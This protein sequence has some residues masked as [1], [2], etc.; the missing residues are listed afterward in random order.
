M[1]SFWD[2]R[3]RQQQRQIDRGRPD[4]GTRGAVT[5]GEQMGALEALAAEILVSAGLKEEHIR[6]T[7][8]DV[9]TRRG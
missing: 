2:T 9:R 8:R 7:L 3:D 5:G 1:Q 6:I 4:A